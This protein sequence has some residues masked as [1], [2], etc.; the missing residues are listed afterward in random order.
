M[1]SISQV[2]QKK[3]LYCKKLLKHFKAGNQSR[4]AFRAR[5]E[6]RKFVEKTGKKMA[7]L[8]KK[9]LA[10]FCKKTYSRRGGHSRTGASKFTDGLAAHNR[11]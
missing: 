10:S 7:H 2:L 11:G 6:K 9:K 5:A 8:V 1:Q 4:A 3:E